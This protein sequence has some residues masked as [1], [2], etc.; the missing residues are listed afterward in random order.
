MHFYNG[1]IPGDERPVGGGRYNKDK[2]GHEL[3]NFREA[4]GHCYGYFQPTMSAHTVA[5][6]CVDLGAAKLGVLGTV[7]VIFVAR[8]PEGGQV[9]VGWYRKAEL[10]RYQVARSPGKPPKHGHFC[11]ARSKDCVLLPD[12]KRRFEIPTGSGGMGQS[13]VCYPLEMRGEEKGALWMRQALR[14]VDDYCGSDILTEPEADA[15]EESAAAAEKALARSKG[16]GFARNQK[17]RK[18]LEQR[19]MTAAAKYFNN[20]GYDVEDVSA[21][22]PYDL[23]CKRGAAVLH[24]EVKGTTTDGEA[25][26]LTNNEVKHACNGHNACALFILHSIK[27]SKG[28][29][30]GGRQRVLRPWQLKRKKLTPVSFTYRL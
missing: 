3:Y 1:S 10:F 13:N 28:K 23:L 26:V 11:W 20:K 16:Q 30:V 14:F 8:R 7:I 5:L 6:E 17:E 22:R 12:E 9:I 15:E 21:R 27:L 25:I 19:A 24:V 2:I 29:A 4:R 18:A